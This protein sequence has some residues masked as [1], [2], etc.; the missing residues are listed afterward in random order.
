MLKGVVT[1]V[2]GGA[3]GLGRA[4][5]ERVIREGGRAVICDLPTSQGAKVA[6]ELGSNALFAPT[7]VTSETDM[8]NALAMCKDKFGRLDAAVS[9]AGVGSAVKTYNAKKK[10]AHSLED[11]I[12]VQTVNLCGTF[13]VVRLSAGLMGENEPNGDGQRGV[14]INT[15]SAAAFDGQIGQAA[16]AASKGGIVAMTLPIAR[17]LASMGIRV[18]AV[19]PG[20]FLTPLLLALPDKV[21]NFLATTVPFPKRLGD[22]DEFAQ[23]VQAIMTNPMMNGEVVRIDGALRM[24]A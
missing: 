14:I 23:M 12:R 11:F 8:V 6:E 2:S 18:C 7:D 10:V 20:L 5:V 1:L 4:T 22:P 3:S 17:D 24:Q 16:Y 21:Q 9:C 15:A 19:S 13:N